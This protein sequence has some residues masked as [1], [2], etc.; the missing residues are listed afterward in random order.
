MKTMTKLLIIGF[1]LLLANLSYGGYLFPVNLRL[2]FETDIKQKCWGVDCGGPNDFPE[3]YGDRGGINGSWGRFVR[4]FIKKE[5]KSG[6]FGDSIVRRVELDSEFEMQNGNYLVS[7]S[8]DVDIE[9]RELFEY[10]I[11]QEYAA[12]RGEGAK[13]GHIFY[14]S[15]KSGN[16]SA[17]VELPTLKGRKIEPSI[18][19]NIP[20]NRKKG[21]VAVLNEAIKSEDVKDP[22]TQ[23]VKEVPGLAVN[24][25][26]MRQLESISPIS[27]AQTGREQL[28]NWV[29]EVIEFR[30]N[31]LDGELLRLPG[32]RAKSVA[33]YLRLP[34]ELSI[35]E[36]RVALF[37]F[38]IARLEKAVED[39]N[40]K[41]AKILTSG[42][43]DNL[44][45]NIKSS[46]EKQADVEHM[47][48]RRLAS[49]PVRKIARK[50]VD[51]EIEKTHQAEKY[52]LDFE[53]VYTSYRGGGDPVNK[54]IME[55]LNAN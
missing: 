9:K 24:Y 50:I 17:P 19:D 32:K 53:H 1:I 21:F 34:S 39:W 49:S 40:K 30:I 45:A 23:M 11:N 44:V 3:I 38:Y 28:K 52:E 42:D 14:A 36:A 22:E 15:S 51:K 18:F 12:G 16:A 41:A 25:W 6:K 10:F 48:V 37:R 2:Q 20:E 4:K 55:C 7:L 46:I 13:R 31:A 33:R 29:E 8:I 47:G 54:P 26:L 35:D 27:D 5:V 43:V